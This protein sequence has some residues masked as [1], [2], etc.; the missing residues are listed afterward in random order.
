MIS[1]HLFVS[2]SRTPYLRSVRRHEH[3]FDLDTHGF[4]CCQHDTAFDSW[5]NKGAVFNL[6]ISKMERFLQSFVPGAD[7]VYTYDWRVSSFKLGD[8]RTRLTRVL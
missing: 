4:A 7:R 2:E 3:E 8:A 1:R 5:T 6:Y